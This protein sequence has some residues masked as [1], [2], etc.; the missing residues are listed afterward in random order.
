MR[1]FYL[2][3]SYALINFDALSCKSSNE[4]LNSKSFKIV[5]KSFIKYLKKKNSLLIESLVH[6]EYF[7]ILNLY[8]H[9]LIFNIDD[10]LKLNS[11]I[12]NND[13]LSLYNFSEEFYNYWR[14]LARFGILKA[15]KNYNHNLKVNDLLTTNDSFN[16]TIITLYRTISQK[17][18]KRDFHVFRQLPAGINANMLYV[19][20]T[21]TNNK[22][23]QKLENIPFVTKVVTSPPFI[24]NS[25]SNKRTGSYQEIDFNPL[26]S[27]KFDKNNFIAFPVYVGPLLAFVYLHRNLLHHGIALTNL[28]EFASY[29]SFKNKKPDLVYVYGIDEDIYDLKYYNDTETNTYIGFV[30]I[31][32]KNDYFGYMKKMLLTLHNVYMINNNNLPIHGAMVKLT[33]KNGVEKNIC[34]V[35]DSGAGKSESL[36]ALRLV[37]KDYIKQMDI[38]FDDMGTFKL[39]NEKIYANG[40][41]TGAF[42]RLDDLDTGYAYE[43]MDRAL[44]LNPNKANARVLIPISSYDLILENHPIDLLLYANNYENL[45]VSLKLVNNLDDALNIFKEGKRFAKGTTTE[46]GLVSTYFANPFG[47]VQLKEKTDLLINKFF[48]S[49]NNNNTQIGIIYTKLGIKGQEKL[50]P[51]KAALAILELLKN[52]K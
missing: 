21:F 26:N 7:D 33:L 48:K 51:E 20:H 27:L 13:L 16:N 18:G 15:S 28:F 38:I 1:D 24:I 40:T 10:A 22:N 45:D 4:V 43:V 9:L 11:K 39:I 32:D 23:Y 46:E 17:I 52:L 49:L 42:V 35:G 2:E 37:G 12:N 30:S 8:K 50:G 6:L 34:I 19:V 36:E 25:K 29:D 31:N 3:N 14:N 47:P 41:E 44:F 5:L